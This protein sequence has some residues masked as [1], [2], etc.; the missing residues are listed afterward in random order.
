MKSWIFKVT[1]QEKGNR[2]YDKNVAYL[3][4]CFTSPEVSSFK[5]LHIR[6]V[7]CPE[8]PFTI[9]TT[10]SLKNKNKTKNIQ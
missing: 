7:Y 8:M 1:K 5:I 10:T 9:R 2:K 6:R 3:A 4:L